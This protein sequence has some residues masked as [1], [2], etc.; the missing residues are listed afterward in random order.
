MSIRSSAVL[1][2]H[3]SFHRSTGQ[4]SNN[5]V[6]HLRMQLNLKQ[7]RYIFIHGYACQKE[8]EVTGTRNEK[9][10][11]SKNAG[12]S[13]WWGR[14]VILIWGEKGRVVQKWWLGFKTQ[15][16][17]KKRDKGSRLQDGKSEPK[18]LQNLGLWK[19]KTSTSVCQGQR[20]G[21]LSPVSMFKIIKYGSIL[22]FSWDPDNHSPP[23]SGLRLESTL[24]T[25]WGEAANPG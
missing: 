2:K 15:S 16:R 25:G 13:N 19:E 7:T 17:E 18:L 4:H 3:E 9:V 5:S 21:W 23:L 20:K 6:K 12:L 8:R 1:E 10:P 11:D 14:W 22:P 24:P